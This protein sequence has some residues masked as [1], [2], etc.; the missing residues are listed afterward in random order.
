[1]SDLVTVEDFHE[2]ARELL[3]KS[4]Y[5]YYAG[6]AGDEWTL[7][8]NRA[9]F[10]RF[11]LLPR[12]LVD[13]SAVD[14]STRVLGQ[15]VS[16]P[17]LAA[18]TALHRMAHPEGEVAT[19]RACREAGTVMTLST[20]ASSTIEEVASAGGPRWFQLYVQ[21]DRRRTEELV[22]RAHRAG[23]SALVLTVDL[24]VLGIRDRD[25]RN[26]FAV[27]EGVEFANLAAQA[28]DASD[29]EGSELFEF[30]AHEHERTLDWG[31]LAWIRSLAPLPLVLKGVVAAEDA[32]LAVEAGV[33]AIVVSNHGGRQLDGTLPSVE[34][35]PEIVDAVDGRLEVYLDGGVRRGTD[36]L[37]ALALG[38]RAVL[39]G[40]PLLWGLA[41]DGEAGVRRILDMLRLELENAMAI[42]G[43]GSIAEI[44]PALVRRR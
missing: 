34:A 35:L 27:P 19:A 7:R 11:A 12:V 14:L 15:Q 23:Y 4:V 42:A 1:V 9:A 18:P 43:C 13:V 10:E 25:E 20:L 22:D 32:R 16:L 38:A 2:R 36:V 21:E 30:V 44:T 3:P 24:P 26:S 6:G 5:D 37:K 41:V 29:T 31:D 33:D 40:R 8:E 28:Q 17:V 39:V